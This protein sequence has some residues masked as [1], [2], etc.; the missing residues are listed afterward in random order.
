[1]RYVI[2]NL[3]ARAVRAAAEEGRGR[4]GRERIHLRRPKDR[5]ANAPRKRAVLSRGTIA[6]KRRG[7]EGGIT[8]L[9]W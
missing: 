1:M 8:R 2:T 7:G 5:A 9:L 3:G 6:T 4:G